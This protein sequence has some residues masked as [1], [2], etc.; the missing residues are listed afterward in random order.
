MKALAAIVISII[1]LAGC[2][3]YSVSRYSISADDVVALRTLP[4]NSVAVGAFTSPGK[5][6]SKIRCRAV[7]PIKTPDG[8]PF[9]EFVRKAMISEMKMAGA[10]S[11]NAP[12]QIT[13][14]LNNI[15]FSSTAARGTWNSH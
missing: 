3:T 12:T 14:V 10:Y 6:V 9:A 8:E 13:G 5:P 2:S 15:N 4:Q 11:E 7:G 1:T